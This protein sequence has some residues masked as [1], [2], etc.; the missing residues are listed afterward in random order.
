MRDIRQSQN[1]ASYLQK[2]GWKVERIKNTNY[3]LKKLPLIGYLLKVQRPEKIEI[4]VID[5][6][7]RKYGV[8]RI[9]IEPKTDTDAELLTTAGYKLSKSPFLPSRTLQLDLTLSKEEIFAGFK[10][11][12]RSVINK[13]ETEA[14]QGGGVFTIKEYL[15]PNQIK[16]WRKGWRKCV[17]FKKYVPG[18][19]Q[20]ISLRKSFPNNYSSFLASHN[21]SGRIIG[22]ALFTISREINDTVCYYWQAFNSNEGRTSLSQYSLLYQGILWAKNQGCKVFDFEGIYDPRFPDKSWLGFTHFKK[23]FGGYEVLYPGAFIKTHSPTLRSV[24]KMLY[25]KNL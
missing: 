2:I 6:L 16:T 8:F 1:Y 18:E 20:L 19:T 24:I 22:G 10:K 25:T 9:I 7:V 21:I 5:K 4:D 14:N 3:F 13:A 15:S 11:D 17:S 12:A 23:S